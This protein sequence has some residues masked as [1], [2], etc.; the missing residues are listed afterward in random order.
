MSTQSEDFKWFVKHLKNLYTQYPNKYLIIQDK[1]VVNTGDSF[2]DALT[3][4]TSDNLELG[5][6]IIQ[7]CGKDE[8]CYTQHF[9][10][11]VVFA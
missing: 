5:T 6:F 3:K 9:N 11:R 7:E 8:E 2:E 10:S 4:A 1:K